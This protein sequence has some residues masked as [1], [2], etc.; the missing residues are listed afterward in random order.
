MR[1]RTDNSPPLLY[2]IERRGRGKNPKFNWRLQVDDTNGFYDG[3]WDKADGADYS[4]I[5]EDKSR[6]VSFASSMRGQ[7]IIGMALYVSIEVLDDE[8]NH[9]DDRHDMI[10]LQDILFPLYKRVKDGD[11]E[12]A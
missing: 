11:I 2:V 12:D 4:G 7:W 3:K 9:E 10:F 8:E 1:L 6:A 5:P